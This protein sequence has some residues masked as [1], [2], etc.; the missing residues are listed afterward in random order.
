MQFRT[1]AQN[2]PTFMFCEFTT[3]MRL[4]VTHIRNVKR[5]GGQ[6]TILNLKN[7]ASLLNM[8]VVPVCPKILEKIS[9]MQ[10]FLPDIVCMDL[11][12]KFIQFPTLFK[13]N[14]IT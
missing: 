9:E 8:A 7:G 6:N 10:L 12:V 11:L 5:I 14:L 13:V 4:W 2:L 3:T 1:L